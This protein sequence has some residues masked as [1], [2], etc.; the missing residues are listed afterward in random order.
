[1]NSEDSNTEQNIRNLKRK[2]QTEIAR[3]RD[4]SKISIWLRKSA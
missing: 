3:K 2:T 1:M 4:Q